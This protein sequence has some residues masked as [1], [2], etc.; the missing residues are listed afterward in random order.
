M[1][2]VAVGVSGGVDSGTLL[3]VAAGALP[4][5]KV[6]ALTASSVAEP[7]GEVDAA[8]DLARSLGVEHVVVD[9][10]WLGIDGIADN[11]PDRCYRCKR[12]LFSRFT[13]VARERGSSALLEGG[14]T[15]DLGDYRPGAKA[16]AELGVRRPMI[17]AG[18]SKADV[19]EIARRLGLPNADRPALACLGSRFPYGARLTAEAFDM[20]GRAEMFLRS[21]GLGQ[22]RVR[23][24]GEVA[25]IEVEPAALGAAMDRRV[26][27]AAR[28]RALGFLFV[29]LDLDGYRTGSQNATLPANGPG[30]AEDGGDGR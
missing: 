1:E 15:D 3:A 13:E 30:A 26:E 16:L 7:P 5:D 17:D 10:D 29:T 12:A 21:L 11:P 27:I 9:V 24:H 23:V 6:L 18:I 14:N 8:A 4:R 19:R 20:A 28:L 2:S 25:R 22:I